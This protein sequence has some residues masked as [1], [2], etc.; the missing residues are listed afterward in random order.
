MK[1]F[2]RFASHV[3]TRSLGSHRNRMQTHF[4]RCLP[5]VVLNR[6]N[7]R[8]PAAVAEIAGRTFRFFRVRH[9]CRTTHSIAT[10]HW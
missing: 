6:L 4:R 5:T 7:T 3:P 8:S 2:L 9:L 10:G 1:R